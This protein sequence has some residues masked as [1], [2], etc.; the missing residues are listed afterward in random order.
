MDTTRF[1]SSPVV[2]KVPGP[3]TVSLLDSDEDSDDNALLQQAQRVNGVN[4]VP[5]LEVLDASD[6]SGDDEDED[7]EEDE[8]NDRFDLESFFEETLE[9]LGDEQLKELENGEYPETP[10]PMAR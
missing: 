3:Q 5:G 9:E 1:G 10:S 4:G 8:E 6:Q 2:V 7:E